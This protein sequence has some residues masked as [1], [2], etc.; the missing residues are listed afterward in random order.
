MVF[1][2][3]VAEALEQTWQVKSS[4]RGGPTWESILF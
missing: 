1:P 3:S 4:K 2:G